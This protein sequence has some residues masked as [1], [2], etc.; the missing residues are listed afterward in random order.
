MIDNY[1]TDDLIMKLHQ[2]TQELYFYDG[3]TPFK[4]MK[5][6]EYIHSMFGL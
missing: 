3:K 1:L 2:T 4:Q 6:K 5:A